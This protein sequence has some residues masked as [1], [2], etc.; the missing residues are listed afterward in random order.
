MFRNLR[1]TII[2]LNADT[3]NVANCQKAK[4]LRKKLLSIGLPIAIIGYLGLFVCF[5]LIVT[6]GF[7][8]FDDDGFTARFIV[9]YVIFVP[10]GIIGSIGAKIASLGFKIVVAGYTSNLINDTVGNICPNCKQTISKEMTFCSKCGTKLNKECPNCKQ[11]NTFNDN[12]CSK[13]GTKLD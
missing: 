10:C 1:E 5:I 9:P 4:N 8:A 2:A 12:F 7:A 6:A 3:N 11:V 13:C